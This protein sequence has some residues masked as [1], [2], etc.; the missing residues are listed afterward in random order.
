MY[1]KR[2]SVWLSEQK[3]TISIFSIPSV[4]NQA[5]KRKRTLEPHNTPIYILDYC[6][7]DYCTHKPASPRA[8]ICVYRMIMIMCVRVQIESGITLSVKKLPFFAAKRAV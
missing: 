3:A 4:V 5:Q 8:C 7:V 2:T 6:T 1:E